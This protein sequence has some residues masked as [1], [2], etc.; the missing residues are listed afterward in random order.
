MAG[1]LITCG[2][3]IA[4][5]SAVVFACTAAG[6]SAKKPA[7]REA[8]E[9]CGP[10]CVAFVL[11]QLGHPTDL[12]DVL[13]ASGPNPSRSMSMLD[14]QSILR[15]RGISAKAVALGPGDRI[16]SDKPVVVHLTAEALGRSDGVGH[17]I[18]WLPK[19]DDDDV[20]YWDGLAGVATVHSDFFY[21]EISPD[22]ILTAP[23]GEIDVKRAIGFHIGKA[24]PSVGS[25]I[26]VALAVALICVGAPLFSIMRR[27]RNEC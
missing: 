20:V 6:L 13:R 2:R 8:F 15:S 11:G 3:S 7:A 10:R 27:T 22:V 21:S 26:G 1:Q 4:A 9:L 16:A 14:I 23:S 17:F 25:T 24:L 5:V 18:V 12:V 19:S